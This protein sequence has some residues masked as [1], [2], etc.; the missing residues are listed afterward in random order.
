M[1]VA[2]ASVEKNCLEG[3]RDNVENF[4]S[5]MTK[6]TKRSTYKN[7]SKSKKP[8]KSLNSNLLSFKIKLSNASNNKVNRDKILKNARAME[9]KLFKDISKIL[10]KVLNNE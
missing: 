4:V 2:L 6:A 3:S 1:Q 10:Y 7:K 8:K 9:K 5:C